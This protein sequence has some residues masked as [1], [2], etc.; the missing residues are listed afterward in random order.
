MKTNHQVINELK[1]KELVSGLYDVTIDSVPIWYLV[2]FKFRNA[3]LASVTGFTNKSSGFKVNK[4]ETIRYF[5]V[6]ICHFIKLAFFM[7]GKKNIVCAFPRL[8][9]YRD[10][11]I[12]KFTDPLIELSELK[13]DTIVLQHSFGRPHYLPRKK[14]AEVLY[15]D[16][17][18]I[19]ARVLSIVFSFYFEYKYRAAVNELY[20]KMGRLFNICEKDKKVI[21]KQ[22]AIFFISSGL[23]SF[24]LRRLRPKN[25]FVVNRVVFRFAIHAARKIDAKVFELQHGITQTDTPL[26]AGPYNKLVDPDLFLVFGRAWVNDFYAI[27]KEKIFNIGWAYQELTKEVD[28]L[29]AMSNSNVILVVS[30]PAITNAVIDF[31]LYCSVNRPDLQFHVRLHPQE[32]LS[33][34]QKERLLVSKN[35]LVTDNTEDS[36]IALRRYRYVVGDNS[37]VLYEA[38]SMGK[39]VGKINRNNLSPRNLD[40]DLKNGFVIIS[41]IED[42]QKLLESSKGRT[43]DYYY[44]PYDQDLFNELIYRK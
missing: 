2:R 14:I 13:S 37:S 24:F 38:L 8:F 36:G 10:S 6:S 40:E 22:C 23:Y 39:F 32:L 34:E 27:P 7:K 12:D 9:K 31:I 16:C 18:D 15:T 4:W 17:I 25:L 20:G 5:F 30:S 1:E 3:H 33:N 44:S 29:E 19:L 41:S 28:D 26:Y 21:T 11:Y 43:S 35:I 42:L